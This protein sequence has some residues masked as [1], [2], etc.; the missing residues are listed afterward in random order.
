MTSAAS[1]PSRT[2]RPS[3]TLGR[4]G[5]ATI[6]TGVAHNLLGTWLYRSQL[7]GILRDGVVDVVESPRV[8]SAERQRRATALWFLMSGAAFATLG[9]AL[10][11][12]RAGDRAVAPIA[13]GMTAMGVVGATVLPRSGFWLLIAEGLAAMW[14]SRSAAR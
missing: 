5:T 7:A 13:S 11:R 1:G 14:A 6:A 2:A 10:R 4:I 12:T 9:A 8:D 3:R